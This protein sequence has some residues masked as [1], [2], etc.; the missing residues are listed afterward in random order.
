[1]LSLSPFQE[2]HSPFIMRWENVKVTLR[3]KLEASPDS[4]EFIQ[5][6]VGIGCRML[7]VE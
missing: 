3:K 5:I 4:S 2:E 6:H 7:K 1:M